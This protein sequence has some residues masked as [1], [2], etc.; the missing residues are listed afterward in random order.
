M[1]WN[2]TNQQWLLKL[3]LTF[4]NTLDR[5]QKDVE[6]FLFFF[7]DDRIALLSQPKI[8]GIPTYKT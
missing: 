7:I 3:L 6:C 1:P 5:S 4:K 8:R 2:Q